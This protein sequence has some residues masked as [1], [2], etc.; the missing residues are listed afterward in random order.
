[1]AALGLVR[2]QFCAIHR[3]QAQRQSIAAAN[4]TLQKP[5]AANARSLQKADIFDNALKQFEAELANISS[6]CTAAMRELK[7][8][9]NPVRRKTLAKKA[10]AKKTSKAKK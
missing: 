1:M 5:N 9:K 8:G 7:V 3:H 6:E 2:G 10:A 4:R